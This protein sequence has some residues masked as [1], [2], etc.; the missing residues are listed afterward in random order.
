MSNQPTNQPN[1]QLFFETI[2]AYQRTAAL[3]AAIEL[4][5][6]SAIAKG[7]DAPESIAAACRIAP[8][9]ARILADYLTLLGF[10]TKSQGRYRLTPDT[11]A[12]LDKASPAYLGGA[13]QFLC[14]PQLRDRSDDLT[15]AARAGGAP[16]EDNTLEPDHDIWVRFARG[17]APL[18]QI[19]AQALAKR[20]LADK[21]T[22]PIK[23]LDV[24]AG[25]GVFG[26]AI[27]R[28]NPNARIVAT[29]WANV[30]AVARENAQKA[31]VI[32]RYQLLPGSAFD[33][34]FGG[35]YD[36][37]LLTNFLHHF[38][39]GAC[40]A[41]LQKVRAAL[42]PGGRAFALEFVPN[43]DRVTPPPSAGFALTMLATTPQG[44]AY[45][46]AEYER[47]FKN[48]GFSRFECANL[49]G[50]MQQVVTAQP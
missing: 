43:D 4:D 20:V 8:R 24:A 33:V 28:H 17:M 13:V 41:L 48:A 11:A 23:V 15:N 1:P 46:A 22:A 26:I 32:D 36:A 39:P 37:V 3:K 5:L 49:E 38:N 30:L 27:A 10:L 50:T 45:T 2:N 34:D 35:D 9:G 18:M 40:A 47:M 7:S 42:K 16:P 31:G 44:D 6:F 29:D 12:F 19:P 21:P 25:H 14:S